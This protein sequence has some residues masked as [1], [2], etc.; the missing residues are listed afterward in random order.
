M[1]RKKNMIKNPLKISVKDS[2]IG[3]F[4]FSDYPEGKEEF[5][6]V[7]KY[8][9]VKKLALEHFNVKGST[10][11]RTVQIIEFQPASGQ[12]ELDFKSKRA[13]NLAQIRKLKKMFNK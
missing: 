2:S 5:T 6:L 4:T 3:T 1:T 9:D 8:V 13:N 12:L 11:F 10:N 7:G